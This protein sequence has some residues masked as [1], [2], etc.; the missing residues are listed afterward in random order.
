M[1]LKSESCSC[2]RS[3]HCNQIVGVRTHFWAFPVPGCGSLQG[4]DG[5]W[6]V[7]WLVLLAASKN[8]KFRIQFTIFL[9]GTEH[10]KLQGLYG[11]WGFY[12]HAIQYTNFRLTLSHFAS[13]E[14]TLV[15]ICI[16][17]KFMN[18][19]KM[20]W[21]IQKWILKRCKVYYMSSIGCI[22]KLVIFGDCW[23][24]AFAKPYKLALKCKILKLSTMKD[25]FPANKRP[26]KFKSEFMYFLVTQYCELWT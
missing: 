16:D 23:R 17:H 13:T 3:V 11:P 21:K 19:A 9:H 18:Q 6:G 14:P 22:S 15:Y 26:I 4:L 20:V 7:K 2:V 12:L 10:R 1:R 25:F 5:R 24:K 8:T